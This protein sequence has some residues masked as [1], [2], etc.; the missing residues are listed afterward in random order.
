M[1]RDDGELGFVIEIKVVKGEASLETACD[2]ALRQIEDR[3]YADELRG[4][5]VKD[6]I[7]YGIAFRDKKCAVKAS[8]IL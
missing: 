7:A 6:I 5:G 2:E 1:E 8:C 3:G 4:D